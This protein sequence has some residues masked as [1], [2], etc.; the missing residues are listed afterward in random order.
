MPDSTLKIILDSIPPTI[1][2]MTVLIPTLLTVATFLMSIRN[3]KSNK[4]LE[5][6]GEKIHV[7]VN[8]NMTKMQSDLAAANIQIEELRELVAKIADRRKVESLITPA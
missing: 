2:A 7:L 4:R 6:Q 5:V 3:D 8:S 1:L